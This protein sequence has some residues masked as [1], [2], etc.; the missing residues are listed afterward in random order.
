[1]VQQ[2]KLRKNGSRHAGGWTPK[3]FEERKVAVRAYVKRK[4]YAEFQDIVT[5]LS[6]KY[7]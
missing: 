7:R 1:M 5:K 6:L 2:I 3:P 4:H